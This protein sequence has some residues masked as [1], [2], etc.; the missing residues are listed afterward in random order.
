MCA[1]SC[2]NWRQSANCCVASASHVEY[3]SSEVTPSTSMG[4]CPKMTYSRHKNWRS[5]PIEPDSF[6]SLLLLLV[7]IKWK[8][9]IQAYRSLQKH[10]WAFLKRPR[11]QIFNMGSF[12]SQSSHVVEK[13]EML[14]YL[15]IVECWC[16]SRILLEHWPVASPG[17]TSGQ[18]PV[19]VEGVGGLEVD[20][21]GWNVSMLGKNLSSS[22][23]LKAI[24]S[25]K[26]K[27][28]SK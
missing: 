8:S 26:N 25:L 18:T 24:Y 13:Y 10:Q 7:V 16:L 20:W 23:A 9:H 6:T 19:G 22:T 11:S 2:Q 27:I 4:V 5:G 14:A 1:A 12:R 28:N 3:Y 15:L 21:Q 17:D